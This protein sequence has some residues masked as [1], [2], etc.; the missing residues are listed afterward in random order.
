MDF[1][2]EKKI[3]SFC[4]KQ[5]NRRNRLAGGLGAMICVECVEHY[6]QIF[7]SEERSR[8][9]TRPVWD[10]MSDPELLAMLPLIMRSADQNSAFA[11]EWV[12]LLRARKISWAEIGKVLGVSRQAVWER[13]A[14]GAVKRSASA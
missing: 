6:H 9:A 5:G 14:K 11:T 2:V 4:G 8:T 1:D 10:D 12:S 13:F 7:A 3:C